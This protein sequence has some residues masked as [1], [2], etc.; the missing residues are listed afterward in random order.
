M[1]VMSFACSDLVLSGSSLLSRRKLLLLEEVAASSMPR[2]SHR[3]GRWGKSTVG[4][5][6]S[7]IV[8]LCYSRTVMNITAIIR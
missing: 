4:P 3:L 1:I 6:E 2:L 8:S 5:T 7:Q